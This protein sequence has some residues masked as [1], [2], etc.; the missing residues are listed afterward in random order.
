[1]RREGNDLPNNLCTLSHLTTHARNTR[2]TGRQM[3][4]IRHLCSIP[5]TS[6]FPPPQAFDL[7]G[8]ER[9][10]CWLQFLESAPLSA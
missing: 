1:M 7:A 3:Q 6:L 4:C 10:E 5:H 9:Q 2:R 8:A